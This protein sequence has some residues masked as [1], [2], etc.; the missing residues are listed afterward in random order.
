MFN[1]F[2][3][4][5]TAAVDEVYVLDDLLPIDGGDASDLV[6]V[7][8]NVVESDPARHSRRYGAPSRFQAPLLAL[9]GVRVD[10]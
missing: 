2:N 4:R 7:K 8:D 9:L 1:L 6:F 5:G 10:L 3:R